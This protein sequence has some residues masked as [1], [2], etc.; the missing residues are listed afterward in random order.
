MVDF[1]LR[2]WAAKGCGDSSFFGIPPWHKNLTGKLDSATKACDIQF[3]N[4]YDIFLVLAALVEIALRFAALLAIGFIIVGGVLFIT[5][6]GNPEEVARARNI[7]VNA[8]I[9]LTIALFATVIV[10]FVAGRF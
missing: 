5:S 2:I 10:S 4:I 6:Q 8:V 3:G 7:L 9:G 1:L